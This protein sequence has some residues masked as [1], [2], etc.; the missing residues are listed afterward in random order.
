[1]R[2]IV[3]ED[4]LL[5]RHGLVTIL[6]HAG[7]TVVGVALDY[8]GAR[9][10]IA[11]EAPDVAILDVRLPPTQRDEGLRLADETRSLYPATAV[12]IL[13]QYIEAEY[14][15]PLVASGVGRVG[16]LL[17]DRVMDPAAVLDAVRRVAAGECVIDPAVVAEL[18]RPK[19]DALAE[20]GLSGRER[21]VFALVAEGLSNAGIARRLFLSERTVEVHVRNIMDKLGVFEDHDVNRRVVAALKYLGVTGS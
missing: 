10:L 3:A 15:G 16:Y 14:V 7:L 8:A 2:V 11:D 1:M 17:K 19:E 18:L 5:T 9:R 21:E 4:Q 6:E 20:L 12:L 13:S